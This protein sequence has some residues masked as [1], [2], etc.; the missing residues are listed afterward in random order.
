MQYR[1][2]CQLI[3]PLNSW[4]HLK[5]LLKKQTKFVLDVLPPKVG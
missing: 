3:I 1:F 2:R 5:L 4:I